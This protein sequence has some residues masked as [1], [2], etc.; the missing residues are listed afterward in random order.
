MTTID[1]KTLSDAELDDLEKK[2]LQAKKEF[3]VKKRQ[4]MLDQ[5]AIILDENGYT[6]RDLIDMVPAPTKSK[7]VVRI[8]YRCPDDPSLTWTGMGRKPAWIVAALAE[9][10]N[11]ADF[12]V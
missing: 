9:G 1:L 11:L 7:R 8:K 4:K 10:K 6:M 3:V 2:V 12:A 5:I